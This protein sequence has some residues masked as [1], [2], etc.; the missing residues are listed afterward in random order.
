LDKAVGTLRSHP[1]VDMRF[2]GNKCGRRAER[3]C[4]HID[5]GLSANGAGPRV[6]HGGH[7]LVN[8]LHVYQRRIGIAPLRSRSLSPCSLVHSSLQGSRRMPSLDLARTTPLCCVCID[9]HNLGANKPDMGTMSRS[10]IRFL[11]STRRRNKT[12][13]V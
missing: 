7:I 13:P 2:S 3:L 12:K 1:G 10:E 9:R 11:S 5:D 6:V 8:A 4:D